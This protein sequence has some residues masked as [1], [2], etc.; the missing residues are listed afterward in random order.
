MISKMNPGIR[1]S[2]KWKDGRTSSTFKR[3]R[4]LCRRMSVILKDVFMETLG[5]SFF[6]NSRFLLIFRIFSLQHTSKKIFSVLPKCNHDITSNIMWDPY[7]TKSQKYPCG[8]IYSLIFRGWWTG[9]MNDFSI[10][11]FRES[12]EG[13]FFCPRGVVKFQGETHL[14]SGKWQV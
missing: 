12:T 6:T 5:K 13:H 14:A 8:L 10:S 11:G 1:C 3:G 4:R 9:L 2:K 7:C